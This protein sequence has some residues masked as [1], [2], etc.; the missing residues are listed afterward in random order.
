MSTEILELNNEALDDNLSV[1]K[2]AVVQKADK[3]KQNNLSGAD[4]LLLAYYYILKSVQID[5][6]TASIQAKEVQANAIAQNNLIN[7][8]AELKF[9]TFKKTDLFN[10]TLLMEW[11]ANG[12]HGKVYTYKKKSNFKFIL[13]EKSEQNE[14]ISAERSVM[15]DKIGE[16]KQS[17]QVKET[18][19]NTVMNEDEQSV[20]QGSALMNMLVSLTNQISQI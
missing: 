18:N 11:W 3:R 1:Q 7:E 4:A 6:E 19:V 12:K 13:H 14:K 8:E 2:E 16:L 5:H 10:K 20:S 15:E 9:N 17:A